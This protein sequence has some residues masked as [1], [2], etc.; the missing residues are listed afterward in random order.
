M[1]FS[2][3][4]T[5]GDLL[6]NAS[7]KAVVEQILPGISSHPQISMARSMTLAA[8]A[9]FSGGAITQDALEKIDVALRS[10]A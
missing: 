6:D 2:V 8:A 1:T 9:P 10:V 4:S 5:I 7:A 3:Q